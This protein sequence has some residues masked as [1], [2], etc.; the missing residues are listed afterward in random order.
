MA[1]A[2]AQTDYWPSDEPARSAAFVGGGHLDDAITFS[3]VSLGRS[4][5]EARDLDVIN[6]KDCKSADIKRAPPSRARTHCPIAT[7]LQR[8]ERPVLYRSHTSGAKDT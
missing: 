2:T 1:D 7:N 4:A 5:R 3:C 6:A 8:L